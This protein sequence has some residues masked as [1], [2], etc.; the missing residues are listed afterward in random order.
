MKQKNLDKAL[1]RGAILGAGANYIGDKIPFYNLDES[2][3]I[4][5]IGARA[6]AEG[7]VGCVANQFTS[8]NCQQG[9]IQGGISEIAASVGQSLKINSGFQSSFIS[10][11]A[12]GISAKLSGGNFVEGFAQGVIVDQLN[13]GY[14]YIKK[15]IETPFN[16]DEFKQKMRDRENDKKAGWKEEKKKFY[17]TEVINK[18]EKGGATHVIGFGHDIKKGENFDQGITMDE[19]LDLFEKDYKYFENIAKTEYGSDW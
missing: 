10:G 7:G 17:P 3:N 5:N 18:V 4:G 15:Q 1:L 11:T 19:A 16:V 9:F 8:G 14:H 13:H 12:G 2:V 6:I